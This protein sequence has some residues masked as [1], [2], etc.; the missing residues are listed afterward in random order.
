MSLSKSSLKNQYNLRYSNNSNNKIQKY[1]KEK[2]RKDGKLQV[3][4]NYKTGI[5]NE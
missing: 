4:G 3:V 2:K 5:L 1:A